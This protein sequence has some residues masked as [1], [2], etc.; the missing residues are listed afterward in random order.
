METRRTKQIKRPA[1]GVG[2]SGISSRSLHEDD[3][4][5]VA[6]AATIARRSARTIRRAYRTG[7]LTAYRDGNGRG[8]RIRDRDLAAG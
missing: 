6:M 1:L 7:T 4:L 5:T 8:I 2:E 3:L